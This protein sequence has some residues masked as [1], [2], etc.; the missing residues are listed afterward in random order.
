MTKQQGILCNRTP[1]GTKAKLQE[2]LGDKGGAQY[3]KE[4]ESL[5]VDVPALKA[6]LK[7]TLKSR[8]KTWLNSCMRCGS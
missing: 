7:N 6:L 8:L 1:I 4:M 3:Y 5:D 2:L